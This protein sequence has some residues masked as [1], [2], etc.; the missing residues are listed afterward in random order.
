MADM[1]TKD[2]S[3]KWNVTQKRFKNGVEKIKHLGQ[4][5]ILKVLLGIVLLTPFRH[6]IETAH[7]NS[8]L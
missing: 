1:G 4:P 3:A 6:Y 5:K 8:F 2:A 7:R